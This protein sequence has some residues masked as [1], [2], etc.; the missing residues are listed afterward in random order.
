MSLVNQAQTKRLV[1]V[2][3]WSG[4]VLGLVL[5]VVVLTGTIAVFALEIGQWSASAARSDAPLIAGLDDKLRELS[6]TLDA[7]YLEEVTLFT[8][9]GGQPVVFFHE[10]DK[11]AEG[12]LEDKGVRFHL[13]PKSLEVVSRHEGFFSELPRDAEGALDEFI[14]NLH[15]NLHAPRPWGLYATGLLGFIM[16][17]AAVSGIIMHKHLLRD[18]FTAPRWSNLVLHRYDR[19][20]LA[21]SWSLPFAFV[22]AFTGVFFSFAG[23]IGLPVVAMVAFGGDQEAM[24]ESILGTQGEEDATPAP[25]S[26]LD[27]MIAD[28]QSRAGYPAESLTIMH[29]GRADADVLV[30]H[31]PNDASL[32]GV[33]HRYEGD[34]G[35]FLGRKPIIG[36][37]PSVGSAVVSLIGPLHFGSFGGLISKFIWCALGIAACYV[38]LT[39]LQLWVQRREEQAAWRWMGRAILVVGYGTPLALIGAG[40]A[41]FIT[42]HGGQ[43]HFWTATG[44]L[45]LAGASIVAGVVAGAGNGL[46]IPL[47]VERVVGGGDMELAG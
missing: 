25:L 5:Y 38:T 39:G 44:F 15:V 30:G 33:V 19:H 7:A 24:I 20:I 3:G 4:T 46:V 1:A 17:A 9:S 14:V 28:S 26:D 8:N 21:G 42:L 34:T 37:S 41:F 36:S 35:D 23:S 13:D 32:A 12:Q 31:G 45:T 22:V 10:H 16:L 2:H 43:S 6:E 29:W 27:A 47:S 11:N 40:I 18:M